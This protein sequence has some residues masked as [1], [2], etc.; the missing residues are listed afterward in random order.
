M[1]APPPN[2]LRRDSRL[3]LVGQLT[4]LATKMTKSVLQGVEDSARRVGRRESLV[5]ATRAVVTARS[6]WKDSARLAAREAFRAAIFLA[7]IF[8]SSCLLRFPAIAWHSAAFA[9][10]T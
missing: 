3:L 5:S 10:V 9:A 8:S 2:D 6:C 4:C 1:L 7:D